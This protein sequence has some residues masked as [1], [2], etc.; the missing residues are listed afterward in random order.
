MYIIIEFYIIICIMLL[1]FNL[2][3][4]LIKNTVIQR[5]NPLKNN[6]KEKLALEFEHYTP[7]KGLSP[8][9]VSFLKNKLDTTNNLLILEA[10]MEKQRTYREQLKTEIKPYVFKQMDH[11]QNKRNNEQ[12]Y[13]AYILSQFNHNPD[14]FK[15]YYTKLL[16]FLNSSS[17]YVFSNTMKAIYTLKDS[18]LL[19][20]AVKKVDERPDLYHSKLLTDG[21]LTFNGDLALFK[22]LIVKKIYRYQPS[23]QVSLLN[24]FRLQKL[25]VD[26]FCLDILIERK[27]DTEVLYATMRY[28]AGNSNLEAKKIFIDVLKNEKSSWI[29]QLL[30]IQGL[31]N[32]NSK[33]VRDTIK[34]KVTSANWEVRTNAIDYLYQNTM[35]LE[36]IREILSDDDKFT[37]ETLYYYYENNQDIAPYILQKLQE[38][39]YKDK[40]SK[41]N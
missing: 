31:K 39:E 3:F 36:E 33:E 40:D 8:R 35:E 22:K 21:L 7:Q 34:M 37:I 12:A 16:S 20:A 10:E 17:F 14:D 13:Y 26:E 27:V 32:H 2:F 41:F 19:A 18:Y 29:E 11:Y 30:A 38:L 15:E 1:L 23:T 9:A 24:Y 5:L 6:S 4:I 25:D 28:F